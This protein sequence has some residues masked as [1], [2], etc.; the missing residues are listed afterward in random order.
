VLRKLTAYP[1]SRGH[2]TYSKWFRVGL[3]KR[4]SALSSGPT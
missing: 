2:V 4:R 3:R 1:L